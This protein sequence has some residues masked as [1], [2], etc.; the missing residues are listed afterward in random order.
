MRRL[1]RISLVF[2]VVLAVL[3]V[4]GIALRNV[5]IRRVLPAAVER[6]TGFGL[7]C[8]A[9]RIGLFRPLIEVHDMVLLNPPEF[10]EREALEIALFRVEYV[11]ASLFSD[12]VH[13]R[14]I[15]LDIPR[16]VLVEKADGTTNLER[17]G[18]KARRRR[19]REEPGGSR[20]ERGGQKEKPVPGGQERHASRKVRVDEMTV[21]LGRIE[22]H[23]YRR[24]GASEVHTVEVDRQWTLHDVMDPA[25]AVS[26]MA[27]ETVLQTAASGL[28]Q[29]LRSR[30]V[31]LEE[32]GL[33]DLGRKLKSALG[34]L[35]KKE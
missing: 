14:R 10:P 3:A 6:A 34:S 32:K 15:E 4:A 29:E 33:S 35:L 2:L 27:I 7:E 30:G 21:K 11:P 18:E 16:V 17:L 13:L 28:L 12:T 1:L 24:S 25:A 23:R 9:I 20:A 19:G 31:R 8:R 22:V 5:I 26:Q